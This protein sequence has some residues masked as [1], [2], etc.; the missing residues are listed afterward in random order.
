MPTPDY[1]KISKGLFDYLLSIKKDEFWK[2]NVNLDASQN[3]GQTMIDD[4]GDTMPFMAWFG[5]IMDKK[6]LDQANEIS[7][8]SIQKSGKSGLFITTNNPALKHMSFFDSNKM[9]DLILGINLLYSLTKDRFY[10]EASKSFFDSLDKLMTSEKGFVSFIYLNGLKLKFTSGSFSGLYIE[11]LCNLYNFT[12]DRT[13]LAQA[14]KLA[15]YWLNLD[16]FKKTGLFPFD[17]DYNAVTRKFLKTVF[18]KTVGCDID[19]VMTSKA[20]TNLLF[21]LTSLY[22]FNKNP[23]IKR[24]ILNWK[25]SLVKNLRSEKGYFYSL[26]TKTEKKYVSL[27]YDHA[28]IDAFLEIYRVTNDKE[29]LELAKSTADAWLK[30]QTET[31]LVQETVEGEKTSFVKEHKALTHRISRLDSQTDF[32]VVLMKLYELTEDKK[33]LLATDRI[34]GGIL[35]YHKYKKGF[36]DIL[37]LSSLKPISTA[38]EVKFLFLVTKAFLLRNYIQNGEKIYKNELVRSLVR[39][40]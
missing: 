26:L 31:G 9:S 19:S 29:S 17:L 10:L 2:E 25:E 38:I 6:Y 30:F 36:A 39:D 35:K 1:L 33:Y 40:R 8:N 21:G 13:Y 16:R 20:N 24:S 5:K 22:N 37:D 14:E 34:L 7:K 28:V 15:S 11:E 18:K 27:A 4:L 23:D 12:K 3:H 32:S